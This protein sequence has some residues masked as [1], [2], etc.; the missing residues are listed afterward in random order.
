MVEKVFTLRWGKG[1]RSLGISE[2]NTLWKF[3]I[4]RKSLK[5]D[6]DFDYWLHHIFLDLGWEP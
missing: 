2:L 6:Q 4:G 5:A 3:W 1:V